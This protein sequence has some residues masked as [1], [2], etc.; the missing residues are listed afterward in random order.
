[1]TR[2]EILA[3]ESL[4]AE[5]TR[6]VEHYEERRTAGDLE[7]AEMWLRCALI[8]LEHLRRLAPDASASN[9]QSAI[10]IPQSR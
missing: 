8:T 2:S 6:Q 4:G 9:P 5:L 10:R 3:G 7:T 1:M